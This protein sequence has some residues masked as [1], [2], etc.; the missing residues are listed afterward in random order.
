V[1]LIEQAVL[2]GPREVKLF[3][4]EGNLGDHRVYEAE[5]KR[6]AV[7]VK[8]TSLDEYFQN[9]D[10]TIDLIKMDVQGAEMNALKGMHQVLQ[11]N[12]NIIVLIEF[13]PSGLSSAG[14]DPCEVIRFL[15]DR[16]FSFSNVKEPNEEIPA[17]VLLDYA[18][19]ERRR[20][21]A[22]HLDLICMR[23]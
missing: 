2:D 19:K 13:W 22:R 11:N 6:P 10:C 3:L 17:S 1:I 14:T 8:G 23:R 20:H 21:S 4:S 9:F 18:R 12:K 7:C 5:E 16:G 15:Q